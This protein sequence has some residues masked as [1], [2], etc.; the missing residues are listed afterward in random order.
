MRY[1]TMKRILLIWPTTRFGG[2]LLQN[3]RDTTKLHVTLL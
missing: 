1:R 3:N 2:V